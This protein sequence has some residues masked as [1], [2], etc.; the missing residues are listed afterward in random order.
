[1]IAILDTNILI[2]ALFDVRSVP[3][4]VV[5]AWTDARFQLLTSDE[6]L[7]EFR[8]VSR[9][10]KIASRVTAPKAGN[11]VRRIQATAINL[12]KL[13]LVDRCP[14][15]FD[16]YLLAM[17]EAGRA[18]YLVTGDKADLLSLV[19]HGTTHIVSVRR[20]AEELGLIRPSPSGDA[21]SP[22]R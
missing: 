22:R 8:R 11:F 13:P 10:P 5:N 20:F 7:R 14:D 9:Y 17:A 3:G 4:L 15:Q 1:M 12:G 6:H 19:R 16:N 2:S 21:G 18:D